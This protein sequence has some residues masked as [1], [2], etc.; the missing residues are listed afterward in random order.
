MYKIGQ[1]IFVVTTKK[2]IVIVPLQIVGQSIKEELVNGQ[3]K[4]ETTFRVSTG[5][6]QKTYDLSAI[7]G[8]Q[9]SSLSAAVEAIKQA[10]DTKL[11]MMSAKTLKIAQQKFGYSEEHTLSDV[12]LDSPVFAPSADLPPEAGPPGHPPARPPSLAPVPMSSAPG[13]PKVNFDTASI[14][15]AFAKQDQV[16]QMNSDPKL[17]SK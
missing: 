13:A 12:E 15:A 2:D 8:S 1:V 10:Y 14:D 3:I 4:K 6:G 16:D 5:S 17:R 11:Q 9:F 7:K